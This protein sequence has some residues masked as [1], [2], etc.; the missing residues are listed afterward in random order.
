MAAAAADSN[1]CGEVINL[2]TGKGVSIG[3]LVELI[4]ELVDRPLT[5]RTKAERQRPETS[6]VD[7]LL[8]SA[9]KAH[10]LID[11][12]PQVSLEEGLS[13]TIHWLEAHRDEY[14]P[15]RYTV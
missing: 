9:E 12:Q 10:K 6:E 1:V 5:I 15:R 14:R 8:G 2:G 7:V 11:W 13:K 3:G 4:G